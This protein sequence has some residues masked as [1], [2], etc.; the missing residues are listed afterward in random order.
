MAEVTERALMPTMNYIQALNSAL[1]NE[2]ERDERIVLLGEDVGK[3]GGVFRVTDGLQQK[4][5]EARVIDTPLCEQGILG[6]AIGMALNGLKPVA[7]IQFM[8]YVLPAYD[9]IA[10]ELATMRYR[11]GGQSTSSV[12]VRMPGCGGIH[13]GHY[14]SQSTESIFTHVPGLHVIMPSDPYDAK[15]LLISSIRSEDPVIFIEPKKL[16][17]GA[18]ADVPEEPYTVPI[19]VAKKLREGD[20]VTIVTW[21]AMVYVCLEAAKQAAEK[22]IE[23]DVIDLR[24]LAP[25]DTDMIIES[26]R[27]TGRIVIVHE[28]RRTCGF[29]AEVAAIV[30]EKALLSLE[31]PVKRVAGFDTH[32]PYTLEDYY[33]PDAPRVLLAIEDT[34]NF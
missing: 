16:Y 30:A 17:R 26:V 27:K 22:G 14:H 5:G 4:F 12:V 2:L 24:S 11:S 21:G 33:M 9:Q 32:F 19:G 1:R 10:N 13:G 31:A 29:G 34:A 3:A 7:E 20:D 18:Q 6:A 25:L 8:D 23:T 15:G 28:A